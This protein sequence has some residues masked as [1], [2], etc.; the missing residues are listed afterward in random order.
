VKARSGLT[1]NACS[2]RLVFLGQIVGG[3]NHGDIGRDNVFEPAPPQLSWQRLIGS[4][5]QQDI[6][7]LNLCRRHLDQ[8]AVSE[9][10]WIEF[11][12]RDA[13]RSGHLFDLADLSEDHGAGI[14]VQI[15]SP[16]A[17]FHPG[18]RF[19]VSLAFLVRP[20]G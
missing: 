6:E 16:V 20:P 19:D 9:V 7:V 1:G 4:L 14:E 15:L 10:R 8:M 5:A 12:Y 3:N 11:P 2:P 18:V 13:D 17:N